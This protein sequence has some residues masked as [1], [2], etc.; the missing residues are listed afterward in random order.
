M[1]AFVTYESGQRLERTLEVEW[2][3]EEND[4]AT[5][6]ESGF[7]ESG[8]VFLPANPVDVIA[9]YVESGA[10]VETTRT[11]V[12][13][14]SIPTENLIRRNLEQARAHRSE[15]DLH[16]A[17]AQARERAAEQTLHR[18]RRGEEEGPPSPRTAEKA[19]DELRRINLPS[20][21]SRDLNMNSLNQIDRTLRELDA[22]TAD[23]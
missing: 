14:A 8:A 10:A 12:V 11:L 17:E 22:E 13:A 6:S 21:L 20:K 4:F 19:G 18:I 16:A 7:F 2:S 23:K 15:I 5:L 3:I 1:W 9:R